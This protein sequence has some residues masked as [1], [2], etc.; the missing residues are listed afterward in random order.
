[1]S[2]ILF[3]GG[4][5]GDQRTQRCL[6]SAH[7]K[8]VLVPGTSSSRI[9]TRRYAAAWEAGSRRERFA[10]DAKRLARDVNHGACRNVGRPNM[11]QLY[12]W[13]K[14]NKY[15]N[16]NTDD[17]EAFTLAESCVKGTWKPHLDMYQA[18]TVS[19]EVKATL[20]NP[21]IM[22]MSDA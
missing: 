3:C 6:L 4:G 8:P 5:P 15:N 1:M 14:C 9:V 7:R 20:T 12:N 10:A 17:E 2:T 22:S 13:H 11:Q 19:L 18:M 21:R 16:D